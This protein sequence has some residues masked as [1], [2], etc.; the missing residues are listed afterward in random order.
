MQKHGARHL[1]MWCK[2]GKPVTP[3][4]F[5]IWVHASV[6]GIPL[7]ALLKHERLS[8]IHMAALHC[9]ISGERVSLDTWH[10]AS[11]PPSHGSLPS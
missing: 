10:E 5:F 9:L 7:S 6:R 11:R 2:N 3:P 4:T 8:H 1:E